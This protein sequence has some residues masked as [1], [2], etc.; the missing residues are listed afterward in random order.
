MDHCDQL[1]ASPSFRG[2]G[3]GGGAGGVCV[4]TLINVEL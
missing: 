3:G 1:G 4:K 2:G